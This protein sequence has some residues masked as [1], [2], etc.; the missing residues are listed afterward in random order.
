MIASSLRTSLADSKRDREAL[1]SSSLALLGPTSHSLFNHSNLTF[2]WPLLHRMRT[3]P[4]GSS[5]AQPP[6][7]LHL[8]RETE[9]ICVG[10]YGRFWWRG[11]NGQ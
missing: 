3:L 10:S 11:T 4:V 9:T 7:H 5:P 6:I 8:G 2:P 1:S